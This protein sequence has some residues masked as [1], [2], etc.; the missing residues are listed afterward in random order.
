MDSTI[1]PLKIK[2]DMV[3]KDVNGEAYKLY[4][5]TAK[6]I[7]LGHRIYHLEEFIRD[8]LLKPSTI[9]ESNHARSCA[10]LRTEVAR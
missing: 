4:L 6:K 9:I 5:N 2:S 3:F 10:L 8:T 7:V 1:P